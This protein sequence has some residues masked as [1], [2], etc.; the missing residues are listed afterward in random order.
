M[1]ASTTKRSR[2]P[3]EVSRVTERLLADALGA[4][5]DEGAAKA[6]AEAAAERFPDFARRYPILVSVCCE[7]TTPA[8]QTNAKRML[9][10]MVHQ[11][12]RI[13]VTP[14]GASDEDSL[15]EASRAVGTAIFRDAG[16]LAPAGHASM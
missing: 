12:G 15:R 5:A 10:L 6:R 8:A 2:S 1:L 16:L 14:D 4:P 9:S 13:G 11:L 7:A 3:E